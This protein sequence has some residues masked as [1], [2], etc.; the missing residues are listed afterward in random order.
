[1]APVITSDGQ[2]GEKLVIT[3]L[4]AGSLRVYKDDDRTFGL[5]TGVGDTPL[6]LA[7]YFFSPGSYTAIATGEPS[8]CATLDFAS[9]AEDP[10]THGTFSFTIT[11]VPV[12]KA[13]PLPSVTTTT[14]AASAT[15]TVT[16]P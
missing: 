15:E 12:S 1:M 4:P 10:A 7:A 11:V 9:C 3:G 16:V 8:G 14:E 5:V 6:D 13:T 2:E